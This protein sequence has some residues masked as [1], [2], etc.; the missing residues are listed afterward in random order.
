MFKTIQMFFLLFS[1]VMWKPRSNP[2]HIE[3]SMGV[4]NRPTEYGITPQPTSRS[5][6]AD[7]LPSSNRQRLRIYSPQN[8]EFCG[9]PSLNSNVQAKPGH[10]SPGPF[11]GRWVVWYVWSWRCAYLSAILRFCFLQNTWRRRRGERAER[12]RENSLS[13]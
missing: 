1:S 13:L 8:Q 4:P 10:Y 5:Q 12:I 2:P 7:P 11:A 6:S 9:A 3:K